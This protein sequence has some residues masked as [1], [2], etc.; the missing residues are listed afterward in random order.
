[1]FQNAMMPFGVEGGTSLIIRPLL[2]SPNK[3]ET[4][5]M[6]RALVITEIQIAILTLH[7]F[8]SSRLLDNVTSGY[9]KGNTEK[10]WRK[11]KSVYLIGVYSDT[12]S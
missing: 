11:I 5:V 2:R 7:Y 1:M 9:R 4:S 12:G 8:N 10:R 3:K 6:S